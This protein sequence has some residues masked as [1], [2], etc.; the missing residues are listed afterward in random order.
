M[1]RTRGLFDSSRKEESV[2]KTQ[3]GISRKPT[4]PRSP[5]LKAIEMSSLG[6]HFLLCLVDI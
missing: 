5:G 4:V 6:L 3:Q 2:V 1:V